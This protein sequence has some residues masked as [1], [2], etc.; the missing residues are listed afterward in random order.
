MKKIASFLLNTQSLNELYLCGC[1]LSEEALL[2]LTSILPRLH[3]LRTLWLTGS[4]CFTETGI[5]QLVHC[6]LRHNTSL[7]EVLLPQ[8]LVS[9]DMTKQI[10]MYVDLNRAG[11]RL[12]CTTTTTTTTT[13]PKE[14][15]CSASS[16]VVVPPG[17][18]PMVLQRIQQTCRFSQQE[19][20]PSLAQSNATYYLLREKILLESSSSAS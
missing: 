13:Q 16:E 9:R 10:A 1:K 4:Q 3:S 15:A 18:W 11:R 20:H 6:G 5:D 8:W 19:E 14:E 12:I 17:L 7:Y 2:S